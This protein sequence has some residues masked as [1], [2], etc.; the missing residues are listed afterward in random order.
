AEQGYERAQINLGYLYEK[1]LGVK[2]DPMTALDW[3]RKAS[4]L[5]YAIAIDPGSINTKASEELQE[6]EREVEHRTRESESLRQQLE[7][8]QKQLE[9]ERVKLE[10]Q[11]ND[12]EAARQLLEKTR[13]ELTATTSDSAEVED[14]MSSSSSGRLIWR[15]KISKK[16]NYVNKWPSWKLKP[17][18][19]ASSSCR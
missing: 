6:L 11:A 5:R 14:W 16:P 3:Y 18:S 9:Q 1:G 7:R 10:K 17:N 8:S 4:G 19:A 13:Q 2:K 12:A 15:A